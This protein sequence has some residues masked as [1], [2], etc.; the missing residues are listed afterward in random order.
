MFRCLIRQIEVPETPEERVRQA[1]LALMIKNLSYP[2]EGFQVERC[3]S[4]YG[5]NAHRLDILFYRKGEPYLLIECK[6]DKI[7]EKAKAQVAGYN[8]WVKAPLV[9]VAAWGDIETGVLTPNGY[10]WQKGIT[11]YPRDK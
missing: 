5:G 1:L 8:F 3:L 6:K 4:Q 7:S 9:A 2:K 11:H 10:T